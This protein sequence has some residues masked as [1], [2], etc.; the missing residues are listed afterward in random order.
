MPA[1]GKPYSAAFIRRNLRDRTVWDG[2]IS[3]LPLVYHIP[4]LLPAPALLPPLPLLLVSPTALL[5]ATV[6]LVYTCDYLGN[7]GICT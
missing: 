1:L 7:L 2:V 3:H 6:L 5:F 4:L